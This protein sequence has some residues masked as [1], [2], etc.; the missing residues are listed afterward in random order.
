MPSNAALKL[1]HSYLH[2]GGSTPLIGETIDA[3]LRGVTRR[4]AEREALVSIHQGIRLTYAALDRQVE[5]LAKGLMAIGIAKGDRVGIWATDNAEWVMLQLATARM[6]AVLV[7]VNPAYRTGELEYA[8]RYAKVQTLF[9]VPSFRTSD[10]PRMLKEVWPSDRVPQLAKAVVYDPAGA[11]STRAPEGFL[12]WQDVLAAGASVSDDALRERSA[13]LDPDDPINIQFT[14][15]T[16]GFPKGVVLTHHN[17]LNNGFFVGEAMRLTERDRL[18]VPV[19]FYHCFGMVVSSLACLTHGAALVIP[20]PHFEAGAILAAVEREKCTVLHGV[21]TM[22]VQELEHPDFRKRDLRSLRTGIMAGAPCPPELV[23]RVI[24][25]MEIR[26]ILIGYGQTEASP[27]THSTRPD[28]SF[29]RRVNTVG[30]NLDHQEVK[31]VDVATGRVLPVGGQGEVCFRGYHVMRG[32]FEQ[33]EAT[34]K[35]I[36]EAGW[37]HSGDLGV[38]DDQG[39]VRITGRIKDMIARGGEKIFPAEIEAFYFGHPKIADIAVFGVPDRVMGEEVAAWIK[40]REGARAEPE[41]FREY[42]RGRIA[43]YKIPKH[44]WIVADFPMTVTGKIQK[45]RMREIAQEKLRASSP[46]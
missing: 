36:D 1:E 27:V 33:A 22:F 16:T 28:D 37:L 11:D 31:V 9:L 14:S 5:R 8:L 4:F 26:E 24:E 29:E 10:Y 30:T 6:G 12:A 40:L 20:A 23:R 35:T 7:N 43:H 3:F 17:I 44:V 38:M 41:E 13:S 15:G 21:P 25:E 46:R 34:R 18:C 19:P 2:R 32:Y 45:F 39:Y 42:A